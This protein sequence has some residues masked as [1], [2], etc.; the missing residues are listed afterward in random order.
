[1]YFLILW[2]SLV[3]C[4]GSYMEFHY[5]DLQGLR[6]QVGLIERSVD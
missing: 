1:M 2:W 3:G 4:P 5:Q 6:K